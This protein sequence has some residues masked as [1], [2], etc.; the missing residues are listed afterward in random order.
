MSSTR[1]LLESPCKTARRENANT[2]EPLTGCS[3]A[4]HSGQRPKGLGME[5]SRVAAP[6]VQEN[7]CRDGGWDFCRRRDSRMICLASIH[8]LSV[9]LSVGLVDVPKKTRMDGWI[10][11]GDSCSHALHVKQKDFRS[12]EGLYALVKRRYPHTVVQGKDLFDAGLFRSPETTALFYTFMGEL[13]VLCQKAQTTATHGFISFLH[14][15]GTLLRWYTQ[16]IDGLEERVL[17]PTVALKEDEEAEYTKGKN[18]TGK[19]SKKFPLVVQLHGN[20]QSVKCTLCPHQSPMEDTHVKTF[21][22]G[23]A[24]VCPACEDLSQIRA[25]QGKRALSRGTLRPDVVLY[26]EHHAEGA[27][28][29]H[30]WTSLMCAKYR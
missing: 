2:R 13:S 27:F 3:D 19:A 22:E 9:C 8:G 30:I 16:N 24:P 23:K 21:R 20:L 17:V 29:Q 5:L 10:S 4:I 14:E 7:A 26:N 25:A 11:K 6:K 28:P 18:P 12:E 1:V 15:R